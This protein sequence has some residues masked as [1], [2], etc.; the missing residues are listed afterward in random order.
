MAQF[1]N[2][3]SFNCGGFA[4]GTMDWYVPYKDEGGYDKFDYIDFLQEQFRELTLSER[5]FT[6]ANMLAFTDKDIILNNFHKIELVGFKDLDYSK[7]IIAY[8]VYYEEDPLLEYLYDYDF[9]FKYWNTKCWSEKNGRGDIR[10]CELEPDKEWFYDYTDITNTDI[11]Y[12]R[13]ENHLYTNY[14]S[15]IIYFQYKEN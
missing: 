9:H 11:E 5:E 12:A 2:N 14:N 6:I 4:L 3:F 7:R 1:K 8:R 10:H 13:N 15:E